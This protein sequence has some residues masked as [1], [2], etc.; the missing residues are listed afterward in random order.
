MAFAETLVNGSGHVDYRSIPGVVFTDPEIATVGKTEQML[1]DENHPHR[2]AGFP[3]RAN[4]RAR[5]AGQTDGFA[6]LLV[7][8]DDNLILGAHLI[9]AHAGELINEVALA[10]RAK[11]TAE[12]LARSCH[13]HPTYGE[14]LKEAALAACDRALHS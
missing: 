3:F 7:D 1:I 11:Q 6:K 4:G 13:A 5:A 2:K 10:M 8:A 14:V 12:S 9:G